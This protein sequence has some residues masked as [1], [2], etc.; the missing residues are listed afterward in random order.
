MNFSFL[1]Y[2]CSN[3]ISAGFSVISNKY[4][5]RLYH[6]PYLSLFCLFFIVLFPSRVC[7]SVHISVLVVFLTSFTFTRRT[8]FLIYVVSSSAFLYILQF[9]FSF[10]L[11]FTLT[12]TI[13]LTY[14][15]SLSY[16]IPF[17]R[18][19]F[20]FV[21]ANFPISLYSYS[22]TTPIRL[23]L[24]PD[25]TLLTCHVVLYPIFITALCSLYCLIRFLSLHPPVR[26][27]VTV[28]R[29]LSCLT[30]FL[31]FILVAWL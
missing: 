25:G 28:L 26:I 31:N 18:F 1:L 7:I 15:F 13:F 12:R 20:S 11:L 30:N 10:F 9:L 17:L 16:P 14:L 27:Y 29:F 24:Y 3:G 5:F 19:S 2:S 8:I 23:F 21:V 22:K 6:I 4:S